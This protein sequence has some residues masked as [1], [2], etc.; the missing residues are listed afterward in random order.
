MTTMMTATPPSKAVVPKPPEEL[1]V[2]LVAPVDS[3]VV[4]LPPGDVIDDDDATDLDE[5][6]DELDC[7][8]LM[9]E[10]VS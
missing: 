7:D 1:E 4:E 9:L 6:P 2:I 10:V 5:E 3:M 8:E